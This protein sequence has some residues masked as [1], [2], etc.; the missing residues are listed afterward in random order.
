MK[1][2]LE[3][4]RTHCSEIAGD[5]QSLSH[6]LHSSKLEYL[7]IVSAIRGFCTELSKQHEL[8]IE[9]SERNLPT[10]LPKDVSLCLFRIAQE[11]LHNAVKYSGVK[12]FIVELSGVEGAVRLVVSDAGAGFDVEAAKK[13]RGLGLLSMQERIHLVHGSFSVESKPWQGTRIIAVVPLAAQEDWPSED[14]DVKEASSVKGM[15]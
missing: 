1:K 3:D 6:Q 8:N 14:G 2:R 10:H 9:F 12:Q 15:P 5:V 13:N 11:A 4:I 7:G